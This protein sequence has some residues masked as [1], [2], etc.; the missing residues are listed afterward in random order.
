MNKFGTSI[1]QI[2]LFTLLASNVS[3]NVC[4]PDKGNMLRVQNVD[5]N[6]TLNVRKG[7]TTKEQVLFELNP[8]D[9][10]IQYINHAYKKEECLELCRSYLKGADALESI[11]ETQ[12]R[13]RNQIWYEIVDPT[14][15]RGWASAKFLTE[16]TK[17]IAETQN[18]SIADNP[19]LKEKI[20]R[21]NDAAVRRNALTDR[22]G[23][24]H[25]SVDAAITS[26]DEALLTDR[27]GVVHES[28]DAAITSNDQ[29]LL[30]DKNIAA[31]QSVD[32]AEEWVVRKSEQSTYI[33]L[34]DLVSSVNG[35]AWT[36]R[37]FV[38]P[39]SFQPSIMNKKSN[40]GRQLIDVYQGSMDENEFKLFLLDCEVDPCTMTGTFQLEFTGFTNKEL[41]PRFL[42]DNYEIADVVTLATTKD[43]IAQLIGEKIVH[44]H[45]IKNVSREGFIFHWDPQDTWYPEVISVQTDWEDLSVLRDFIKICAD[46]CQKLRAYGEVI[47]VLGKLAV[48]ADRLEKVKP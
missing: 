29:A 38:K 27:N 35:Q 20:M 37:G 25:E 39:D 23:V 11:I 19:A 46:R 17:P 24:V 28:V 36:I 9:Q 32:A 5:I 41:E 48:D 18:N 2:I 43:Y 31:P 13:N 6:D 15:R 42:I 7:W 8:S 12:C 4:I 47:Q 21:S 10:N 26:N 1:F 34:M 3:A 44:E 14:G 30:T 40:P 16:Y 45:P 33:P 22:N